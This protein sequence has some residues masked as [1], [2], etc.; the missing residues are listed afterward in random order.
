SLLIA[1]IGV[2]TWREK[3]RWTGSALLGYSLTILVLFPLNQV[4]KM[5]VVQGNPLCTPIAGWSAPALVLDLVIL[6]AYIILWHKLK[7]SQ[8]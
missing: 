4:V 6:G 3:I 5:G 2:A 1:L 7:S 8:G